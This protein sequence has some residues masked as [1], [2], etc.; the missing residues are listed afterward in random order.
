MQPPRKYLLLQLPW[1]KPDI[2]PS[3]KLSE[4]SGLNIE[5]RILYLGLS[6]VYFPCF[7]LCD[8]GKGLTFSQFRSIIFK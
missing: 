6:I 2:F 7:V 5:S 3:E 4:D 1:L 8:L